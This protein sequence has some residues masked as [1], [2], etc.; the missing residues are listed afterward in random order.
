M[1]ISSKSD[2]AT[3]RTVH[4]TPFSSVRVCPPIPFPPERCLQSRR[5]QETERHRR[6]PC[7]RRTLSCMAR[8]GLC[9]SFEFSQLDNGR[10]IHCTAASA[11]MPHEH[12][13]VYWNSSRAQLREWDQANT[14]SANLL[15]QS[16]SYCSMSLV[17]HNR[18]SVVTSYYTVLRYTIV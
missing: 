11:S 15:R 13:Q 9:P 10:Q 16:L 12:V 18:S 4:D 17:D 6:R 5:H 2:Q 3:C 7:R 14:W 1:S 8:A